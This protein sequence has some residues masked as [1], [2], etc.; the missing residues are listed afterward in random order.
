MFWCKLT[1]FIGGAFR[2]RGGF[3]QPATAAE[4]ASQP[5]CCGGISQPAKESTSAQSH[6][7]L[8]NSDHP[9]RPF[10]RGGW[11]NFACAADGGISQRSAA[12]GGIS[13]RSTAA[14]GISR[15][16]R[17][18]ES[19][20]EPRRL[21]EFRVCGGRRNQPPIRGGW[22]K[23]FLRPRCPTCRTR[24][25]SGGLWKPF[26]G[27]FPPIFLLYICPPVTTAQHARN[28]GFAAPLERATACVRRPEHA[29]PPT[30]LLTDMNFDHIH[31]Q[32]DRR[33]E[34]RDGQRRRRATQYAG[35]ALTEARPYIPRTPP[36]PTMPTRRPLQAFTASLLDQDCACLMNVEG[37]DPPSQLLAEAPVPLTAPS[38]L[39]AW[40]G[41][42]HVPCTAGATA[43][44]MHA[45][46]LPSKTIQDTWLLRFK[47]KTW[48]KIQS[49][50]AN[51]WCIRKHWLAP[52]TV[53]LYIQFVP[54]SIAV[55]WGRF[56]QVLFRFASSRIHV[57]EAKGC[58]FGK[59]I[60]RVP[61]AVLYDMCPPVSYRIHCCLISRRLSSLYTSTLRRCW[62]ILHQVPW[63]F[64]PWG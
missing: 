29:S 9:C 52:L 26:L 19:A 3:S 44:E 6:L 40:L 21:A 16:R 27:G 10:L 23:S 41:L 25:F 62:G 57:F 18:A 17:T 34:A 38:R 1:R 54:P 33:I 47:H 37:N 24:L 50:E 36:K 31:R 12:D 11:R 2:A 14:G 45:W 49:T 53:L 39:R 60:R 4:S 56:P 61:P 28:Q 43:I 51:Y 8:V 35:T 7:M 13:H 64:V 55:F 63:S 5:P 58:C 46:R 22:R 42:G 32:N 15:S 48:K 20:T 59:S 30:H